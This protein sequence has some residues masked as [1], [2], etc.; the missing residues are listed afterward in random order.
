MAL[1]YVEGSVLTPR[2]LG[3][4]STAE[5]FIDLLLRYGG[6]YVPEVW[7][8]EEP[9]RRKFKV[10]TSEDIVRA[11]TETDNN[12]V[13]FSRAR[14]ARVETSVSILRIARFPF[15]FASV[16]LADIL[17]TEQD[18]VKELLSFCTELCLL[19]EA[20]RCVV[21][22]A[23]QQRRQQPKVIQA[24]G[25]LEGIYWANFFGPPYI[26]F[27]GRQRLL[28]APCLE[29]R[30]VN[31]NLILLLTAKSPLAPEMLDNDDIVEPIKDHLG[32]RAFPGPNYPDEP[33]EVPEFDFGDS[34]QVVDV[35]E[36]KTV[37]EK[38]KKYRRKFEE[39]GYQVV[40]ERDQKLVLK[41]TDSSIV[42]IDL[43]QGTVTLDTTG[44]LAC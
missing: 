23:K 21:A 44:G 32:R 30:E 38:I 12:W 28:T 34:Q 8:V 24:G 10:S 29:V 9:P 20:A 39:K 31:E 7:D 6:M 41:G 17:L 40:T 43:A 36:P 5:R 19:T 13:L 25:A 11:W 18:S 27:F 33:C 14:P 3:R 37:E 22:H 4:R 35:T 16:E 2:F 42:T 15:N 1:D 26:D